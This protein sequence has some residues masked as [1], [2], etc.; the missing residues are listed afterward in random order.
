MK[1]FGLALALTLASGAAFAQTATQQ[2][3]NP[4]QPRVVRPAPAETTAP[5]P[6]RPARATPAQAAPTAQAD[7]ARPRRQRSPA[8]LANDER[9]RRCGA[10]WRAN[11]AALQARGQNW[12]QF[13]VEC[14]RRLRDAGSE[15]F[16]AVS[17]AWPAIAARPRRA[18]SSRR[19]GSGR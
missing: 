3:T 2:P 14:R 4:L 7:E 1:P 12:R 6:A 16:A 18:P 10:E 15:A 9:M 11:R 5:A 13:S 8:Q 19:P 17:R